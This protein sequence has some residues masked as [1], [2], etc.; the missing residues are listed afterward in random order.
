MKCIGV[1]FKEKGKQ[2]TFDINNLDINIGDDVIVETERGLQFGKAVVY[3]GEINDGKEHAKVLKVATKKDA[4]QNKK[5][6]FEAAKALEK[7]Q[8]LADELSLD[9]KFLESF[10]TFDRK[11]LV[12]QFLADN[13]VDFREL[14]KSLAAIYK[15]RIELRQVGV[16]DK[17]KE[18][19]GIG[20]CGRKLCC[21]N[22]LNDLDS[23]GIA[24]VKNQNLALN[25][26]KINGLCGRL[27]CCLKFEDDLYTEFRRD[28]PEIGDTVK[29][30]DD[31][32]T[33]TSVDIPNRKYTFITED[34]NKIEVKV[35]FKNECRRKGN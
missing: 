18:I 11:Q 1:E 16:R 17:A 20:P 9:M 15:T 32:G 10:Y 6:I 22:F 21:S 23:V 24:Q 2:Y 12:F 28:L 19:S 26:S 8:S 34:G 13:R 27:L 7:A 5:N 30:G 14:A 4:E 25:P 35:P 33:V 29:N 3:Y 31:E